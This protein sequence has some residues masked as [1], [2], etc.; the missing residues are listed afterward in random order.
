M[1]R[2]VVAASARTADAGLARRPRCVQSLGCGACHTVR[3]V[4]QSRLGP[5]LTNVSAR[6]TIGAGTLPGGIGNIAGWTA[7]AQ[8]LKPGNAMQS[9]DRLEGPQLGALAEYLESLK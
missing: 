5:D 4:S 7:S 9:Y 2:A 8:H 6:R 3:S 1:A